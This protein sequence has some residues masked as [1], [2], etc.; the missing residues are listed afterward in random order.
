MRS[1]RLM[2]AS[3]DQRWYMF[4]NMGPAPSG[5]SGHA[6]ATW[7]NKVFVL[8]GESYT[9]ASKQSEW[10]DMVQMLDTGKIKYPSD[11]RQL[12]NRKSSNPKMNQ[13]Q[14]PQGASAPT[15]PGASK[16]LQQVA[17][18][19]Q[20][21]AASPTGSERDASHVNGLKSSLGKS[22]PN[23]GSPPQ[24]G[25]DRGGP[26]PEPGRAAGS[27]IPNKRPS[28]VSRRAMSPINERPS[29]EQDGTLARSLSPTAMN[30]GLNAS[31]SSQSMQGQSSMI[32]P[33]NRSQ[34]TMNGP[35]MATQVSPGSSI[36]IPPSNLAALRANAR[37][38]SPV[39]HGQLSRSVDSTDYIT[40]GQSGTQ[41]AVNRQYSPQQ[42][43]A[44]QSSREKWLQAALLAAVQKG[45]VLPSDAPADLRGIGSEK[46]EDSSRLVDALLAMRK[47]VADLKVCRSSCSLM[48]NV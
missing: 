35:A 10:P 22:F 7:Q 47:E 8:G 39:Q 48:S 19:E 44:R 43:T 28:D 17:M 40:P 29:T 13:Q 9:P 5:R 46:G 26:S 12:G 33:P 30:R 32:T 37:S 11:S 3:A 4:T 41:N 18:E 42:D 15:I 21:R 31:S 1:G 2:I 20:R 6:M 23:G 25:S 34:S 16:P 27:S 38:P 36:G 45:F 24:S 14:Q